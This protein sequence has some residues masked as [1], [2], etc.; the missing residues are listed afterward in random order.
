MASREDSDVSDEDPGD[1]RFEVFGKPGASAEPGKCS[2]HHPAQRQNFE[3]GSSVGTRDDR[4]RPLPDLTQRV[5]E[6]VAGIAT[7]DKD[8]PQPRIQILDITRT[9]PSRP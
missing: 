8:M 3:T 2:F 1:G 7:I 4:D 9:A 6:L 5:A